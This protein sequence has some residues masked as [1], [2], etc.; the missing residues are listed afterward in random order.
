MPSRRAAPP[1]PD[2]FQRMARLAILALACL[3][4]AHLRPALADTTAPTDEDSLEAVRQK[5]AQNGYHFTVAENWVSRMPRAEREAMRSRGRRAAA[6]RANS[7]ATA[8]AA[9]LPRLASLPSSFDWRNVS[10][11]SYI[12]AIR[13]QGSCGACYAFAAA[14]TAEGVYNVATHR[15][16]D[17]VADFSEQYLAFCLGSHGP[18]VESFDGCDGADYSYAELLALTQ[19][20]IPSETAMPYTA[21]QPSS[22][23]LGDAPLVKFTSWGRAACND[24]DAIKTAILTYGPVDVA[25]LT[26]SL[27]D[28]YKTGVFEDGQ[29]AC[30]AND[31]CYNTTTDHAVTLVGWDDGDASTPGH[32]ILRNSWGTGWGEQGYMRIAY[33]A[34]RVACAAA[35]L[36]YT[37]PTAARSLPGTY[38]LLL[39]Q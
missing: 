8:P 25:V 20:G 29:D 9:A 28:Y 24:I 7:L 19:Y 33:T 26:S 34:A 14:A 11:A 38:Q 23:S 6:A 37:P 32:W 1:S 35:Y 3:F 12:G 30:T 39:R 27:F 31:Y 18:Y 22:C 17:A 5:I 36:T 2:A 10:G 21:A 15:T 13:N 16:G 4:L